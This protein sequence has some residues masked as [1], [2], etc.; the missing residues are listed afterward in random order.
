ML[1]QEIEK[2]RAELAAQQEAAAQTA[3]AAEGR[4]G[5]A[6]Q[7]AQAQAEA[8]RAEAAAAVEAK[9]ALEAQLAAM[10]GKALLVDEENTTLRTEMLRMSQAR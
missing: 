4:V 7:A 1:A 6:L 2:L 9:G 5:D 8:A 3:A 10:H